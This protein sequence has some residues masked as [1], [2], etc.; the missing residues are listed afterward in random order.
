MSFRSSRSHT[1][2]VAPPRR[3]SSSLTRS[4]GATNGYQSSNGRPFSIHGSIT[5]PMNYPTS[6]S[7]ANYLYGSNQNLRSGSGNDYYSGNN[8]YR[9]SS[10]GNAG[11]TIKFPIG[12][13]NAASGGQSYSSPYKDRYSQNYYSNGSSATSSYTSAYKDRNYFNPYT[14]Y[15][16]GVTTAS[17]SI[18]GPTMKRDYN[19]RSTNLLS[20]S[21]LGGGS[22]SNLMSNS[23]GIVNLGRSQSLREQ[24]RKSRTRKHREAAKNAVPDSAVPYDPIATG[25]L[26]STQK[27]LSS[28]SLQSEGYESGNES[29]SC[30]ESLA[31]NSLNT[32]DDG[33]FIDYKALYEAAKTENELLRASL[34]SREQDLA[35]AKLALER[36]TA[37]ATKSSLSENEKRE[38]RAMERKI[39]EMEEE[40]KQMDALKTENQRLKDENGAL[41]RVISKLSK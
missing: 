21:G 11:G 3:R 8:D 5:A 6:S 26:A 7:S 10:Y 30:A 36:L 15:D 39:S 17:L 9:R 38:K 13:M 31:S 1:K 33:E 41:I 28:L 27:S 2:P 37:A 23:Q 32:N 20:T 18:P 4:A 12:S 16:N 14:S 40:L 29:R 24:E 34:K 19:S 35:A 22:N 25:S